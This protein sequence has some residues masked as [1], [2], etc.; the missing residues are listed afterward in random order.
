[1]GKKKKD[2]GTGS[3]VEGKKKA[4]RYAGILSHI[5][6]KHWKKGV[7]SFE[8]E[9][10]EI[11][12]AAAGLGVVLPKNLG[13]LIYSFRYRT[14]MPDDVLKTAPVGLEWAIFSAGRARYRMALTKI[15]RIV[16][17]PD[18]FE[19]KVLDATPQ[20]IAKYALGDEQSLLAKVR[21]NRLIDTFLRITAYSL[22][23]HLRTTVPGMGQIETDEVY[24]G[25][26]NT[27]QQFIVPVQAKGGTDQIG[28]VQVQQDLALCGHT[29]PHLTPRPVAV[30]FKRDEAGEGIVMFELLAEG[31]EIKVIDEKHYRLVLSDAISKQEL[32]TFARLSE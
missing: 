10:A 13:D 12:E 22:Q 30:Q 1:M 23:N 8:F 17:T 3:D 6:N 16:P 27:G 14:T 21:Y 31:D 29:F 4:T 11:E 5:F 28:V 24:V 32:E 25:V 7:T 20:I 9:R 26:R 2:S 15:S 19:I 18:H